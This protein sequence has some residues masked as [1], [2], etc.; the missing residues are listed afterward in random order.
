VANWAGFEAQAPA[1]A[2]A[3]R[4]LLEL[5]GPGLGFLATI[6]PDGGP[7]LHPICPIVHD[8]ELWAFILR[9]SPKGRDLLRDHRVALH[10]FPKPDTDDEFLA[11][12]RVEHVDAGAAQRAAVAAATPAI[13]GADEEELFRFEL[14]RAQLAI[15]ETRPQW[16]PTYQ[17]W[18]DGR[19]VKTR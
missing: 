17:I 13:V 2:A 7:R 14:D 18:I 12:G 4:R 5:F 10:S 11:L 19:G 6:R 1:L 9:R 15:Y 16:P 8:G 3:G